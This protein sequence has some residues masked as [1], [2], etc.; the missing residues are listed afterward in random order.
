M[1]ESTKGERWRE[2]FPTEAEAQAFIKGIEYFE[3]VSV[4]GPDI[5]L[6][7]EGNDEYVVY[8]GDQI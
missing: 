6:D 2:A 1:T 7:N 3:Q 4:E 5:E 8:I